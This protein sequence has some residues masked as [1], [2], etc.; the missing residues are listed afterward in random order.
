MYFRS[1][2]SSL[3][4]ENIENLIKEDRD[5][6]WVNYLLVIPYMM[7]IILFSFVSVWLGN[8]I[9]FRELKGAYVLKSSFESHFIFPLSYMVLVATKILFINPNISE[10]ENNDFQSLLWFFKEKTI[11]PTLRDI[12]KFI[13]I[14]QAVYIILFAVR[15]HKNGKHSFFQ[16]FKTIALSYYGILL[17]IVSIL[18]LSN[19]IFN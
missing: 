5:S 13:T 19:F 14:T 1:F 16:C 17:L 4:P 9:Y 3:S 2:S 6:E 18:S 12:L 8:F 11:N 10:I 7:A 15:L